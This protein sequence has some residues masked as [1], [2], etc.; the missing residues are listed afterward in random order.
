[1]FTT[2]YSKK[3][4]LSFLIA[5][6]LFSCSLLAPKTSE[7]AAS[8]IAPQA[9][10]SFT[11]DDGIS[12]DIERAAPALASYGFTGTGY[13]T[14]GCVGM[15]VVPNQCAAAPNAP[16]MSWSQIKSLQNSYG[17]EIGSHS[18]SHPL[19]SEITVSKIRKELTDSKRV[20]EAQGIKVTSFATPYGDYDNRVLQEIAKNYTSHRPFHD[21]G[22]NTWPYSNNNLKVQ[23]VQ[24]GV[25]VETVQ[26]YIDHAITNEQWLILVFHDIQDEASVNPD[27]YQYST[28]DLLAVA[29]YAKSKNIKGTNVSDGLVKADVADNLLKEPAVGSKLANGWDTDGGSSVKVDTSSKGSAPEPVRSV[30]VTANKSVKNTHVFSPKVDI[31]PSSN[32]V[33][34]GYVNIQKINSGSI[35]FY[36]DEYDKNGNWIS[37]QY[38]Q[39]IDA[40]YLKD[41]SFM[42][43]ASSSLVA[44]ASL[45]II[46]TN[47][48]GMVVYIDNIQWF[49][50]MAGPAPGPTPEPQNLISNGDFEAGFAGWSTDSSAIVLNTNNNG[51]ASSPKNSVLIS[52]NGSRNAHLFSA[53]VAVT[54]GSGYQISSDLNI[55]SLAGELGFYIDE[56]DKNGNWISGQYLYTKSD[57]ASG[58]VVFSYNPTSAN[59]YK[60]SLQV[61]VTS[62]TGTVVYIDD[63]KWTSQA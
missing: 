23:Q 61:I 57:S 51:S 3:I 40:W 12:S 62:G 55:A 50:A 63:I 47:N 34:K 37:G 44:R 29:A 27:D 16:H 45:Q 2:K 4:Y 41:L 58:Q 33:V 32:Y 59:V 39:T 8:S 11:F 21:T 28:A 60:S 42:Y 49:A 17:W 35:G 24:A 54:Y 19:M 9:Q 20:L 25:S 15:I 14:T 1:M 6:G 5:A 56:Y 38:K 36:I 46:V 52:N 13:I 7:A 43:T 53:A 22:Y 48:S 26:G 18:V 31:N 30:K 10:I